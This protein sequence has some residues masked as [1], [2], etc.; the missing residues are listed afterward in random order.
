MP[1]HMEKSV[2]MMCTV[3]RTGRPDCFFFLAKGQMKAECIYEII[4]FPKYH[5]NF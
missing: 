2:C 5:Q 1:I 3:A 4:D